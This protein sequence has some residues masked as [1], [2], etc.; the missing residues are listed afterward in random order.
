MDYLIFSSLKDEFLPNRGP[1][2]DVLLDP[3]TY[4]GVGGGLKKSAKAL[5]GYASGKALDI[6]SGLKNYWKEQIKEYGNTVKT[7]LKIQARK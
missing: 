2:G 7:L 6:R 1:I 5:S 4:L 3:A